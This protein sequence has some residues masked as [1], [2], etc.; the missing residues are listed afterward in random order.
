[1]SRR[2]LTRRERVDYVLRTCHHLPEV[3]VLYVLEES[4]YRG[5]IRC[6]C[7]GVVVVHPTLRERYA[8]AEEDAR[9]MMLAVATRGTI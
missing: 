1:M 4:G 2:S 3:H 6:Q 8:E 9:E 5:R 7:G